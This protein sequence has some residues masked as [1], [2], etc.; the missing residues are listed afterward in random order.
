MV[1]LEEDNATSLE[2][3]P[4]VKAL[5]PAPQAVPVVVQRPETHIKLLMLP[6]GP[7]MHGG[8]VDLLHH[9]EAPALNLRSVDEAMEAVGEIL[10]VAAIG[11]PAVPG[12]RGEVNASDGA[13]LVIILSVFAEEHRRADWAPGLAPERLQI[14]YL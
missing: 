8:R 1:A 5:M 11:D 12:D 4:I 9:A 3:I 14:P 13:E 2:Q 6:S 10:P 7:A